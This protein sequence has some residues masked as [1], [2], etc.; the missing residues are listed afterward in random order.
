MDKVVFVSPVH[1][2]GHHKVGA[3]G[4]LDLDLLGFP[5]LDYIRGRDIRDRRSSN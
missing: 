3:I 4:H 2:S 1:K 5:F